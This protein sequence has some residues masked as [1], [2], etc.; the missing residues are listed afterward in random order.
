MDKHSKIC[1]IGSLILFSVSPS[2]VLGEKSSGITFGHSIG[3]IA[4]NYDTNTIFI[5]TMGSGQG[6]EGVFVIDG[7]TNEV[8]EQ[9]EMENKN[10]RSIAVNPFTN[11]MYVGYTQT[12]LK[13]GADPNHRPISEVMERIQAV[14]VIDRSTN[15][16][17]KTINTKDAPNDI[18]INTNTN[19][20]FVANVWTDVLSVIDGNTNSIIKEI[21]LGIFPGAISVNH[22]TNTVYVAI[23]SGGRSPA[24]DRIF[25]IDGDS[26]EI[27]DVIRI[28]KR[29]PGIDVNP[30]TNLVYVSNFLV[31]YFYS[32]IRWNYIFFNIFSCR[33]HCLCEYSTKWRRSQIH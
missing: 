22:N 17:I 11:Q 33:T 4:V 25:V 23:D 26:L 20:I 2:F 27:E 3:D 14:D 10:L 7:Q 31:W 12:Q 32:H 8:I 24:D 21:K 30:V 1:I 18:A 28:G 15:Q 5:S 29:H 13:A 9:I 19:M 16:I 6:F